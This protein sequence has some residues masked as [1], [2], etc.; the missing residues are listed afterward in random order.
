MKVLLDE[1]LPKG[2]KHDFPGHDVLTVRDKN[3]NS[4]KNGELIRLMLE[5]GFDILITFD[6]NIT[7]QQNLNKYPISLIVLKAQ[8][9]TYEVLKKFVPEIRLILSGKPEKRTIILD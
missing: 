5:D 2:L 9:N 6:Q 1:N 3:W 7:Y 8:I 4:K